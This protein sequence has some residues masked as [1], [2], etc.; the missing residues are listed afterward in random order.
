MRRIPGIG[1]ERSDQV[2]ADERHQRVRVERRAGVEVVVEI[3]EA[4]DAA[5]RRVRKLLGPR[6]QLGLGVI[7][8]RAVLQAVKPQ[9]HEVA[10][11]RVVR[12]HLQRADP[13]VRHVV[14]AQQRHRL[15][16]EPRRV[17]EL[18]GVAVRPRQ[19]R[20]EAGE[21]FEV[22]VVLREARRQLPEDR[23]GAIAERLQAAE[24]FS[25]AFARVAQPA[26]VREVAA[27]FD[28]ENEALGRALAP[29][30]D[31]L[32]RR[33]PIER[34]VDLDGREVPHVVAEL[35][36]FRPALRIEVSGPF[37]VDPAARADPDA[38]VLHASID[39]RNRN[40]CALSAAPAR[41]AT[42]GRSSPAGS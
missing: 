35:V 42:R 26:D 24:I 9:V 20:E 1:Q 8:V 6:P 32:E 30:A 16:V 4:R 33:Q 27:A 19:F 14:L 29:A 23:A 38:S 13:H 18:D 3:D 10:R 36:L 37:L 2:L 5:A 15:L 31:H 12:R 7:V 17:P 39:R 21:A 25:Q 40:E 28:G 11:D 41:R 22:L 34:G